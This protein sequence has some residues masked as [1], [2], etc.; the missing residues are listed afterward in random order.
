MWGRYHRAVGYP[1]LGKGPR[2]RCTQLVALAAQYSKPVV[3]YA[4]EF[5]VAGGLL[6]YASSFSESFYQAVTYVGRILK[7]EKP[8]DLPILQPTK[9]ELVINLKTAKALG[10]TVPPL[11]A[12]PRRRGDRISILLHFA[13]GRTGRASS[14]LQQPRQLWGSTTGPP[15]NAVGALYLARADNFGAA[16]RPSLVGGT[17]D[18]VWQGSPTR[19][20]SHPEGDW[21]ILLFF[22]RG[23]PSSPN[24][25]DDVANQSAHNLIASA[26]LGWCGP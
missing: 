10:L 19:A 2:F 16:A 9:F 13:H 17:A 1:P 21:A 20:R 26:Q 14:A 3:Y 22:A 7:G 8:A 23:A 6:S 5:A 25:S 15:L 24:P 11:A 12:R 18:P 4:R